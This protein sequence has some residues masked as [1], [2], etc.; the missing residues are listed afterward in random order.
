MPSSTTERRPMTQPPGADTLLRF[1]N[2][3]PA[4]PHR[5]AERFENA[6]TLRAWL[7]EHGM[8]APATLVTDADATSAREF[9]DA[10]IT[11]LL[12]HA[13]DQDITPGMLAETE[14]YLREMASRYPLMTVV[15]CSGATLTT[16]QTGIPGLF[17][18][19]LAAITQL[20]MAGTWDRVRACRNQP[21]HFCFF[22]RT[23]NSSGAYCGPKCGSQASMR[24]YRQR[25]KELA[26]GADADGRRDA[27][28]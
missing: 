23:R 26:S 1:V 16:G 3:H 14:E 18:S 22:D 27:A 24:A 15:T 19:V 2:T 17:G 10:L 13:G 7:R 5:L 12:A 11:V 28:T 4:G 20:A 9:R 8:D 6:A 21:C 25:K